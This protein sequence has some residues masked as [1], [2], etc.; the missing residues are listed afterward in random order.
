M[1]NIIFISIIY[2]IS[3][4]S[5]QVFGQVQEVPTRANRSST[6]TVTESEFQS[7]EQNFVLSI[8]MLPTQQLD[9]F[10]KKSEQQIK[11]LINLIDLLSS[12]SWEP[13]LKTK[14]EQQ[15]FNSFTSPSDSLFFL[16]GKNLKSIT[17]KD[18]LSELKIKS[19]VSSTITVIDVAPPIIE[20]SIYNWTVTFQIEEQNIIKN[21]LIATC[22][23]KKE[24]KLFGKIE[25]EVWDVFIKEIKEVSR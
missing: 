14:L 5:N 6:T 1:K 19:N 13:T 24:K 11:D 17:I 7:L 18:Y 10:Q 2:L 25:R 8:D 12:K 3:S 9:L 20:N 15:A 4:L 16:H 22:K 23:L 21:K